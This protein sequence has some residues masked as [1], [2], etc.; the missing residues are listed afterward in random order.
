VWP[1]ADF[2]RE[3]PSLAELADELGGELLDGMAT[4]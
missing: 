4:R 1:R 2:R 3:L